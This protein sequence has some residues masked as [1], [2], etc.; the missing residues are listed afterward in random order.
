M[1]SRRQLVQRLAGAAMVR[2]AG[3]LWPTL[4]AVAETGE[5][6]PDLAPAG[7]RPKAIAVSGYARLHRGTPSTFISVA[8]HRGR[9]I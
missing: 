5:H 3:D 4:A 1:L 6:R 8:S 7:T 2:G 9:Q